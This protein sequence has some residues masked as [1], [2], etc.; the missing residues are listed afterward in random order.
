MVSILKSS[1]VLN[2]LGTL[3][4]P[5]WLELAGKHAPQVV[6]GLAVVGI[7]WQAARLTWLLLAP[8]PPVLSTP[9][10]VNTPVPIN[11]SVNARRIADA[12]LFGVP[13]A[14]S[15]PTDPNS[16]PK[17]QMNLVLAG[18]MALEDPE[19]GFAIIGEST[20]NA[21]FYRVG[22][23]I[24]GGPRLH[25]VYADRVIID[26]GGVLETLVLPRGIPSNAPIPVARNVTINNP[27]EN[28]RRLA[29]TNPGALGELLRAQP[30]FANGVQKGFRI[31]PGRD[32]QQF[33]RLGLQPGDLVTAINGTSLDDPARSNE[34]LNTMVASSTAQLTLERNGTSQTLSLDMAQIS[35]PEPA[36]SATPPGTTSSA[37]AASSVNAAPRPLRNRPGV[38]AVGQPAEPSAE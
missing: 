4:G 34:I 14:A 36:N 30:V 7:A 3:T 33:A 12:H 1:N 26:R 21:K 37:D 17:S 10:A 20:A 27:A 31:Y 6:T 25:S 22:A 18:T 13:S 38:P 23:V 19:A 29:A 5:Q 35:I 28:I 15:G 9:S 24:S 16:L 11:S 8:T 32:R 2:Q